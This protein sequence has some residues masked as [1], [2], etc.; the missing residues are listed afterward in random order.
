MQGSWQRRFHHDLTQALICA[1]E[2][3]Q[4]GTRDVTLRDASG[5][6]VDSQAVRP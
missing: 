1:Q 5:T 2:L 6:V 3:R 4:V